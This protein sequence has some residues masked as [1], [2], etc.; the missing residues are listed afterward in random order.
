MEWADGPTVSPSP[1]VGGL[2]GSAEAPDVRIGILTPSGRVR[3]T[4]RKI[5]R[6]DGDPV[7]RADHRVFDALGSCEILRHPRGAVR[8][9]PVRMVRLRPVGTGNGGR[10]AI[11]A[12]YGTLP[13]KRVTDAADRAPSETRP[14]AVGAGPPARERR[15]RR[16]TSTD[17]PTSR[18]PR[19]SP[20]ASRGRHAA[21]GPMRRRRRDRP[22]RPTA[23]TDRPLLRRSRR[24]PPPPRRRRRRWPAPIPDPRASVRPRT[25][26]GSRRRS[27]STTL[28]RGRRRRTR[29]WPMGGVTIDTVPRRKSERCAATGSTPDWTGEGAVGTAGRR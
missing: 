29:R 1:S 18:T 22:T 6:T 7:S 27:E 9:G 15:I 25:G 21:S 13:A 24:C 26:T 20:G 12:P 17:R 19:R 10:T 4:Q 3:G 8:R 14:L 23:G 11:V 2:P 28:R 16:E 5:H